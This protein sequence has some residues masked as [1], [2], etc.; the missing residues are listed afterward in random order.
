MLRILSILSLVAL[1]APVG[2]AEVGVRHTWGHSTNRTFGGRSV[3]RSESQGAFAE[4]SWGG[5]G[6]H[7]GGGGY[8]RGEVGTTHSRT[9]ESFGFDGSSTTGFSE[10]S[11]FSR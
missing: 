3:T 6:G 7:G 5:S 8:V 1:A 2:A 9:R 11:V 10:S 4:R